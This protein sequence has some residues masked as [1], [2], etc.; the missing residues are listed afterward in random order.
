MQPE[1]QSWM[2][3]LEENGFIEAFDTGFGVYHR[4]TQG[5]TLHIP[6]A[7]V[8]SLEEAYDPGLEKGGY[9]FALPE[10][11]EGKNFLTVKSVHFIQNV[12][13]YPEGQYRMNTAQFI[14][15]IQQAQQE[16]LLPF[17]FHTHPTKTDSHLESW[18]FIRQMD[19]SAPDK[20]ASLFS[21]AWG[22]YKLR[23]PNVL[24]IGNNTISKE[25]F[26]GLFGGL[27]APLDFTERKKE[28][29]KKLQDKMA[30]S[31]GDYLDS[32]KKQMLAV[33][34]AL[35]A[36]FLLIKYPKVILPTTLVAGTLLPVIA[37]R[38]TGNNEHFAIANL[39][40]PL[41]I[42]LPSVDDTIIRANEKYIVELS[43]KLNKERQQS[44]AA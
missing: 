21:L 18:L 19:T 30:D 35:T 24:V 32:P 22:G 25:I 28:L 44:E 42:V 29:S 16:R 1:T 43:K 23:L 2:E 31:I 14:T 6:D 33:A 4:L 3:S 5:A 20:S 10:K 34:G 38:S 39:R 37:Y 41:E 12:A 8:K 13:D 27:V 26:I 40:Q 7:V 11:K 9:L 15:A 36:L 17:S